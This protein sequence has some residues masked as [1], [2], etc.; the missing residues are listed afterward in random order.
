MGKQFENLLSRLEKTMGTG[1]VLLEVSPTGSCT[2]CVKKDA[3]YALS[4]DMRDEFSMS[5]SQLHVPIIP[6][7]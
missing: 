2:I 4:V 3:W 6:I 7:E 5:A 1:S